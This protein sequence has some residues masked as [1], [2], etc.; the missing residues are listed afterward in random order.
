MPKEWE[1]HGS[2]LLLVDTWK[3]L[4]QLGVNQYQ[5]KEIIVCSLMNNSHHLLCLQA[6][7]DVYFCY[8][9]LVYIGSN[10]GLVRVTLYKKNGSLKIFIVVI[11][12]SLR[13]L[14]RGLERH[15]VGTLSKA[16][17]YFE[18]QPFLQ[19]TRHIA[20]LLLHIL[21]HRIHI[22]FQPAIRDRYWMLSQTISYQKETLDKILTH[23]IKCKIKHLLK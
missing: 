3:L 20:F 7:L 17:L 18:Q 13:L 1:I 9:K 16:R 15:P 22:H 6:W 23:D 12:K 14:P 11:V 21:L 2:N 8:L 4:I 5:M 10:V 19:P